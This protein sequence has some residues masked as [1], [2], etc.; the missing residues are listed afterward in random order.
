MII[1]KVPKKKKESIFK[2][3]SRSLTIV[4]IPHNSTKP[5]HLN[6]TVAFCGFLSVL[7]I[8]LTTWAMYLSIREVDYWMLKGSNLVLQAKTVYFAKEVYKSREML[9]HVR[10][11]DNDLRGLLKMRSRQEIIE[12]YSDNGSGGPSVDDQRVLDQRVQNK[13]HEMTDEDINRQVKTLKDE[14]RDTISSYQ[15][16]QSFIKEQHDLFQATPNIWPCYGR[17]TSGFG[18]RIHPIWHF[19]DFHPALDIANSKGT[20]IRATADGIVKLADWM[21]G[22][23]KVVVIEHGF[24]FTTI[25]GHNSRILVKTGQI[26]KRG[27]AISYMGDT[28][29]ATGVHVH[30]EVRVGG[31]SI[32]P[33]RFIKQ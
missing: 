18:S 27:Q 22:Y 2:K 15:E 20:P 3:L 7:W 5:I 33:G 26:V 23:G 25:Y 24:G 28:G 14:I 12:K 16:I 17:I 11:I 21:S 9:E 13:L 31:Q 6:F 32:N 19:N 30:Y 4:F 8:S 10:E 1:S 29:T